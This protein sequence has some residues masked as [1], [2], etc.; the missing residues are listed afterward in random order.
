[1]KEITSILK[2]YQTHHSDNLGLTDSEETISDE[3]F[4]RIVHITQKY[5]IPQEYGGEG[6]HLDQRIQLLSWLSKES[7][8]YC[9]KVWIHT[10]LFL[11]NLFLFSE[12]LQKKIYTD[13]LENPGSTWGLAITDLSSGSDAL[14]MNS[15]CSKKSDGS[16]FIDATKHF[17]WLSGEAR[18]W[19]LYLTDNES[20]TPIP[21]LIDTEDENIN[22]DT[23]MYKTS[24]LNGIG[25][26]KNHF[27][28]IIPAE[29]VGTTWGRTFMSVLVASRLQFPAMCHG[30]MERI[31]TEVKPWLHSREIWKGKAIDIDA[32]EQGYLEIVSMT[33]VV[34]TLNQHMVKNNIDI[35]WKNNK[36]TALSLVAKALSTDFMQ[37]VWEQWLEVTGARG[38]QEKN[39]VRHFSEDARPFTIFEWN[40]PMLYAQVY[41]E[42]VQKKAFPESH[43]RY[44][45]IHCLKDGI[46]SCEGKEFLEQNRIWVSLTWNQINDTNK[47]LLGKNT[48]Q[49]VCHRHV[50][51]NVKTYDT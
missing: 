10:G 24:W 11:Q 9:L 38:Y 41:R 2:K 16:Y 35:G 47:I 49:N 30:A 44:N 13:C 8:Q 29:H 45:L 7:L 50:C 43:I 12:E 28:G 20:K 27:S 51:S 48:F 25:Y 31:C 18:Y 21:F 17:Q 32:I 22:V 40:N 15:H 23:T 46:L 4:N 34:N 14:S 5:S 26:G 6:F 19:I 3:D 36:H 1:M 37:E 33:E 39:T 42:M